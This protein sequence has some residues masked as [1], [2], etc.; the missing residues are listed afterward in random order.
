M[1]LGGRKPGASGY[2]R[3]DFFL[4]KRLLAGKLPSDNKLYCRSWGRPASKVAH[5]LRSRS[6]QRKRYNCLL[7]IS[8]RGGLCKWG[9]AGTGEWSRVWRA[10]VVKA[11]G[12]KDWSSARGDKG[13]LCEI[14]WVPGTARLQ[15]RT[16][17]CSSAVY[18]NQQGYWAFLKKSLRK[19]EWSSVRLRPAGDEAAKLPDPG[20]QWKDT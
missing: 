9:W 13:G 8:D 2:L 3:S 11:Q 4:Q 18:R 7:R 16:I 15:H 20:I 5:L 6:G 14:G 19:C 10:L 12:H 17:H 1:G